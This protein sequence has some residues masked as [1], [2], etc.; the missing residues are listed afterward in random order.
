MQIDWARWCNGKAGDLYCEV[1]GLSPS[2]SMVILSDLFYGFTRYLDQAITASLK[3]CLI[4][5]TF[6]IYSLRYCQRFPVDR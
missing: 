6:Q 5:A 3:I 4:H 1:F 2:W